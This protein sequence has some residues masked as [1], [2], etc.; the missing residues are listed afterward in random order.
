MHAIVAYASAWGGDATCGFE[1]S[2]AIA[3]KPG[4][5]AKLRSPFQ[6]IDNF[7]MT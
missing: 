6:S 5:L 3:G 2:S 7:V 4:L 1:L